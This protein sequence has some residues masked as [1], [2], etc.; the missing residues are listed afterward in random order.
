MTEHRV[1]DGDAIPRDEFERLRGAREQPA[2]AVFED[3]DGNRIDPLRRLN[4]MLMPRDLKVDGVLKRGTDARSEYDLRL[5]DGSHIPLG[6]AACVLSPRKVEAAI[7]AVTGHTIGYLERKDFRRCAATIFALAE[8]D[9]TTGGEAE[10][11]K[12]WLSGF[13]EWDMLAEVDLDDSESLYDALAL[14]AGGFHGSD[15]RLYVRQPAFRAYVENHQGVRATSHLV[16][17]SLRPHLHP[18]WG[19][20]RLLVLHGGGSRCGGGGWST[21]VPAAASR[22]RG[23]AS[24]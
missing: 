15:R 6:S 2:T 9:R 8:W 5:E 11:T 14:D 12:E 23:G 22:A 3:E 10:E 1:Q 13:V 7:A 24:A 16:P 17:P 18:R 19:R 21:A 20:H 4:R